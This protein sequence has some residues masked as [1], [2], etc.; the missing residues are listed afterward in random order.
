MMVLY[1]HVS[2]HLA[3]LSDAVR[4]ILR[5]LI[6]ESGLECLTASARAHFCYEWSPL[7]C[8][9]GSLVTGSGFSVAAC[10]GFQT[11]E[12]NHSHDKGLIVSFANVTG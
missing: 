8:E 1:L 6:W 9:D 7:A 11:F 12:R 3:K 4:S 10:F 5:G 2:L